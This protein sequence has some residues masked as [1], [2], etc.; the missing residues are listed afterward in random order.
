[1]Y[2]NREM[3][4]TSLI[5]KTKPQWRS[6]PKGALLTRHVEAKCTMNDLVTVSC[7]KKCESSE[8]KPGMDGVCATNHLPQS[9]DAVLAVGLSS[10]RFELLRLDDIS[11]NS[12]IV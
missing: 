12:N 6:L 8:G 9:C 10:H 7:S 5:V 4:A 3:T 1:M 2:R 11:N